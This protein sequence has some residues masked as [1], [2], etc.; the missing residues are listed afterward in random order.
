MRNIIIPLFLLLST[1]V[2]GKTTKIINI[3]PIGDVKKEY[4]DTVKNIV[5]HF[6]G[7]KC[8]I[9]DK[10]P[11][12]PDLLGNSK[13]RYSAK[14]IITKFNSTE[15]LLIITEKDIT[16]PKGNNPEWGVIGLGFRPGTTAIVSTC[17]IQRNVPYS[18]FIDRLKKVTIHEIGHNLGLDHCTSNLGCIMND[19]KGTAKEIDTE[20]FWICTKCRR[21]LK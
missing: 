15:N 3:Q 12:S 10:I 19:A 5:E 11:F 16:A 8:K 1:T 4:L 14:K 18:R 20:K 9:K 6:Y 2:F 17:R 13:K 7:F 21:L